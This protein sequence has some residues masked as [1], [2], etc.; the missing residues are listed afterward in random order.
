MSG[1]TCTGYL[2]RCMH[3]LCVTRKASPQAPIALMTERHSSGVSAIRF[4]HLKPVLPY[5]WT[6]Q[7]LGDTSDSEGLYSCARAWGLGRLKNIS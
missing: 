2:Q 6:I 4:L 7:V 1:C 5:L 3:V